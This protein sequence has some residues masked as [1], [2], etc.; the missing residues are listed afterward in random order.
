MRSIL[1]FSENL[2]PRDEHSFKYVLTYKISQ[3][4]NEL[5]FA[6]IRGKGGFNNNPNTLQLKYA[7]RNILMKNSITASQKANVMSFEN[8]STGSLFSL[9]W[10]KHRSPIVEKLVIVKVM[11][12]NFKSFQMH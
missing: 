8:E 11:M 2:L 4:H 7:L 6:C 10:S 5:L 9:K 1:A 12:H 3:D